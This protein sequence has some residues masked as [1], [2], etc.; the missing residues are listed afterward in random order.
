MHIDSMDKHSSG[1]PLKPRCL[2]LSLSLVAILP[3][4]AACSRSALKSSDLST[5]GSVTAALSETATPSGQTS[6]LSAGVETL[7]STASPGD[8]T[9]ALTVSPE[10]TAPPLTSQASD[11]SQ[12]SA[13][14]TTTLAEASSDP[15]ESEQTQ[16]GAAQPDVTE[17]ASLIDNFIAEYVSQGELSVAYLDLDSAQRYLLNAAASYEA[18]STI[19]VPMNM[20]CYDLAF[21]GQLDL[22]LTLTYDQAED[23][24]ATAGL[25]SG[26]A[27]GQTASLQ[28]LLHS[29]ILYSDN[30]ATNMIFRYWRQTSESLS[31]RMDQAFDMHYSE[32]GEM[33]VEEACRLLERL[34]E[35][36]DENPYYDVLLT[37][38]K[39]SNWNRYLTADL[40]V[41][42]AHKYGLFD[43]N[44]H[45]LTLVYTPHPYILIVYSRNL[46]DAEQ[47]LP[48]LGRLVYD[49][50]TESRG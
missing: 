9:A 45:D 4:L 44:Q 22:N 24:E 1:M 37:D 15:D 20:Y 21:N 32:A 34:Y 35:N 12:T 19:K 16:S 38:M 11:R 41:T 23:Y 8:E 49:W 28:T 13:D 36:P 14:Q 25:M 7:A 2:L 3:G 31:Y 29:A 30:I 42:A 47:I 26:A 27:D 10:P 39:N 50:Q 43:G 46:A 17:L 5:T 18:A 33:N 6:D 48:Q 40:P